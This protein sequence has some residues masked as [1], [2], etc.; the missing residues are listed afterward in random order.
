MKD[1]KEEGGRKG[2]MKVEWKR[3]KYNFRICDKKW[4]LGADSE[5]P[6]YLNL[7]FG[8]T[9]NIPLTLL[10]TRFCSSFYR[11]AHKSK[12][13]LFIVFFKKMFSRQVDAITHCITNDLCPRQLSFYSN[14]LMFFLIVWKAEV[15]Y[16]CNGYNV[17]TDP[18]DVLE[19]V[20][21]Q[22]LPLLGRLLEPAK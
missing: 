1:N 7:F 5:K 3:G 14:R 11:E 16:V 12:I 6:P 22:Q 4:I 19:G 18:H 20:L 9:D 8:K 2:I 13:S 17:S 21:V 15:M 10:S